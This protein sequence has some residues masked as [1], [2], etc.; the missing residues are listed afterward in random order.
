MM[1]EEL[2]LLRRLLQI[3]AAEAAFWIG[4]CSQRS[5]NYYESGGRAVPE[6]V[7]Q[8]MLK[9]LE[10]RNVLIDKYMLQEYVSLRSDDENDIAHR[11]AVAHVLA[12][13][14]EVRV[15]I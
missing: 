13:K 6:S 1:F 10:R 5:W 2:I 12:L 3:D 4:K 14:P 15:S 7:K 8:R 9:V 11:S